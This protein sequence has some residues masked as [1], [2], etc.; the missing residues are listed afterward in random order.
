[1]STIEMTKQVF[2]NKY[3]NAPPLV[4]N[5]TKWEMKLFF[6]GLK[7]TNAN[8]PNIVSHATLKGGLKF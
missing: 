1:M 7:P 3:L 8:F 6:S 5:S 4:T 2:L